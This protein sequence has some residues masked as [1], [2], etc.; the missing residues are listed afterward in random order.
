M[1]NKYEVFGHI[2]EISYSP[3]GSCDPWSLDYADSIG[4]GLMVTSDIG[5]F[6]LIDNDVIY[7]LNSNSSFGFLEV[8]NSS[9]FTSFDEFEEVLKSYAYR[10]H[11]T[12]SESKKSLDNLKK[13]YDML[14]DMSKE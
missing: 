6:V 8:L 12:L 13:E 10:W 1:N 14:K 11:C 2:V 4:V 7:K 3:T 9:T 5:T